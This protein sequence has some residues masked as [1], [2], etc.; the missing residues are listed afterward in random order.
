MSN[1]GEE[2]ATPLTSVGQ[3]AAWLAAGGK[4]AAQFRIGTEHEKFGFLH[5]GFAAPPYEPD[6]IRA[7][8]AG[9]G[10]L[11]WA[12]IEDQ[13]KLIGLKRGRES[14]ASRG[15]GAPVGRGGRTCRSCRRAGT[16]SCGATWS[17]WER[18]GST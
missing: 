4:P 15:G 18:S 16:R 10:A 11:G 13:G 3:L 5:Q 12:P 17:A 1:P 14:G 7:M 9:I 8:L 2:D 6:G